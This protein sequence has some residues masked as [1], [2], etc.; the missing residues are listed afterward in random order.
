MSKNAVCC[1][2]CEFLREGIKSVDGCPNTCVAMKFEHP[3]GSLKY[4]YLGLKDED[5]AKEAPCA[6][7]YDPEVTK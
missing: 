4:E 3:V 1:R 6:L 7:F 5:L 2:N